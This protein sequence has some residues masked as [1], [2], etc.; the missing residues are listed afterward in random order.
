M[1]AKPA[2]LGQL[3]LSA[4][5]GQPGMA[6]RP[7]TP[8]GS[9]MPGWRIFAVFFKNIQQLIMLFVVL[10]P[11]ILVTQR[12]RCNLSCFDLLVCVP[13]R[14]GQ[15]DRP[16][17]PGMA[18]LACRPTGPATAGRTA[19]PSWLVS[20]VFSKICCN[21]NFLVV[22]LW[23][24]SDIQLPRHH[25]SDLD[26]LVCVPGRRWPGRLAWSARRGRPGMACRPGRPRRLGGHARLACA[27]C[28]LLKK[29][30]NL[31]IF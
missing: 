13:G 22:L 4:R 25:L 3:A 26:P 17:Q 10:L 14:P 5:H 20:A 21:L 9:A 19:M 7:A 11:N 8:P 31:N 16:G 30:C 18:A 1:R 29:C 12:S 15:A 28:F 2:W 24:I 27:C 23:N 6:D